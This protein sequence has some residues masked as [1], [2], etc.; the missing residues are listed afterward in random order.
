MFDSYLTSGL[1]NCAVLKGLKE[2][3]MS[4]SKE[5]MLDRVHAGVIVYC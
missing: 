3:D 4:G 1:T 2:W 5:M